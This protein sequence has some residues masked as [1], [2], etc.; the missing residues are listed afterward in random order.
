MSTN[1]TNTIPCQ[2]YRVNFMI[3][4]G[5]RSRKDYKY[6][7]G[8]LYLT[9]PWEDEATRAAIKAHVKAEY[10]DWILQGYCPAVRTCRR[11]GC[12]ESDCSGCIERTGEPCR[13]VEE[14]LC[15]A[16]AG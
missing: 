14:T 13:W 10:P 5:K 7:Y 1:P 15:S 3:A 2:R 11:C 4:R 8:H 6:T 12:T 9:T 16:C